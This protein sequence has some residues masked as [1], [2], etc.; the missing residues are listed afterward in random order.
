MS[1]NW[2][3]TGLM[4]IPTARILPDGVMR[5]GLSKASPYEWYTF[6]FGVLP[7]L[8]FSGRYTNITNLPSGLGS[9]YGS[10]KDKAYDLKYQLLPESKK[11]PAVAFGISD[12]N[13]TCLFL[14]DLQEAKVKTV[15][16]NMRFTGYRTAD[17]KG[18]LPTLRKRINT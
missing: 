10:Y 2:G 14:A 4:E 12:F 5:L 16:K 7:G 1:A 13:G 11:A 8:E 6:G 3:G 17:H 9:D 15:R 18:K